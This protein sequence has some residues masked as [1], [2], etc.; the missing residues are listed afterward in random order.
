M[1]H[2]DLPLDLPHAGRI[3]GRILE[4]LEHHCE[5][6]GIDAPALFEVTERLDGMLCRF[7]DEAENPPASEAAAV[8]DRAAELSRNLVAE[9][10]AAGIRGDRLGQYIRNLFECL[11]L[12]EEGAQ[13]S[14]RAGENPESLQRPVE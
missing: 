7:V 9:L 12:G 4:L 2:F 14:I 3:A 1:A 5:E 10:E 8:R 6:H 11:A 13:I